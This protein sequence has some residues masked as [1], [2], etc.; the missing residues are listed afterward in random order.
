MKRMH[1]FMVGTV[2]LITAVTGGWMFSQRADDDLFELKK[3]FEIFGALY[4]E[5]IVNYVDDVRPGPFM[6]AG[7]EAM[8]SR[9]D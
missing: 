6:T 1:L 2:V 5:I 9:L 8:M 4:Q 7:M 3:N